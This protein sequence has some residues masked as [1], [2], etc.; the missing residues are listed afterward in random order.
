MAL[1]TVEEDKN[2][3]RIFDSRE[4]LH[5]FTVPNLSTLTIGELAIFLSQ[6]SR[7]LAEPGCLLYFWTMKSGKQ[8]VESADKSKKLKDYMKKLVKAKA[9]SFLRFVYMRPEDNFVPSGTVPQRGGSQKRRTFKI[10]KNAKNQVNL[11]PPPVDTTAAAL[12]PPPPLGADIPPPPPPSFGGDVPPPPPPFGGP[13]TGGIPP[14]PVPAGG[15]P[16][17]VS[18]GFNGGPPPP[19]P[20]SPPPHGHHHHH[21][22]APGTAPPPP[23][24]PPMDSSA[25]PPPPSLAKLDKK[26]EER[27]KKE[28]EKRKKEAEKQREKEEKKRKEEEKKAMKRGS[29]KRTMTPGDGKAAHSSLG[30]I[31]EDI[32]ADNIIKKIDAFMDPSGSYSYDDEEERP[33]FMLSAQ[34]LKDGYMH[35]NTNNATK[36]AKNE[37][38]QK[39]LI[40]WV[41]KQLAEGG[42]KTE[43]HNLQAD[44]RNGTALIKLLQAV[45]G[46][47]VK[48]WYHEPKHVPHELENLEIVL[49]F[50]GVLGIPIKADAHDIY[51]GRLST[52]CGLIFLVIQFFK[53]EKRK[54]NKKKLDIK[55][56]KVTDAQAKALLAAGGARPKRSDF[57]KSK[58]Q[59]SAAPMA[60]IGAP[61]A[62]SSSTASALVDGVPSRPVPLNSNLPEIPAFGAPKKAPPAP[63]G[64]LPPP[65]PGGSLPPPM[66]GP[67]IPP[68]LTPT[69]PGV[70]PPITGVPPKIPPKIPS[71]PPKIPTVVPTAAGIPPPLATPKIPPPMMMP[72]QLTIADDEELTLDDLDAND[73]LADIDN[74]DNFEIPEED[75]ID[76]DAND[77]VFGDLDSMQS[78]LNGIA[79]DLGDDINLDDI[80]IDFFA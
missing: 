64:T 40:A 71:G 56:E 16:P 10:D 42:H 48:K 72:A 38:F 3:I 60:P 66:T 65:T 41:N 25:P 57:D 62:H 63:P 34:D 47:E 52:I 29:S 7:W 75:M 13:P 53:D 33:P 80:N 44:L 18:G 77:D 49:K 74:L 24:P 22:A 55:V 9:D 26:E 79:G 70:P 19:P 1:A 15:L 17:P 43:I 59:T 28:E 31:S 54:R 27:R 73:L 69:G 39:I 5:N 50:M 37:Q 12:P 8:D 36:I 78:M 20:A 35:L 2:L 68:P 6:Q 46:Q 67:G 61:A 11:P 21:T 23:P 45:S 76:I 51:N 32:T 4:E 58:F 14:P 30:T